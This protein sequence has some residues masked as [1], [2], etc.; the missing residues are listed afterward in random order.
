MAP[1]DRTL[2]I[3]NRGEI[4]L[5]VDP[6]LPPSSAIRSVAIFTE[7]DRR[8]PPCARGRRGL[9]VPRLPRHRRGGR[10]ARRQFGRTAPSTPATASCPSGPGSPAALE[11]AGLTLVGPSADGDGPDGSQG[12]GPR[13]RDRGGGPGRAVTGEPSDDAAFPGAGQGGR[14]RRRQGHADRAPG[15]GVRR[16][17]VAAAKR[18]AK[19]A[20]GD[21]TILVE[22]YVEHGR[23]IE[24]QV[25]ADAHGH[26][27]A[28]LRARLLHP[29]P[30]PEGARGGAGARPSRR[31]PQ[32]RHR[33]GG[34]P[35]RD[36]SATQNAGTV[37]FLLDTTG[38]GEPASTSSR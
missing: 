9:A 14:R 18:E 7:L 3:A 8:G 21:D 28:P 22:K 5:R 4:A 11:H 17:G 2:L 33:V 23:H 32:G 26:R 36:T 13:D 38:A 29:A 37:E 16:R 31:G 15:R 1:D 20:F 24:V 12:R 30:A 34:R 19:A 6:H 35:G 27:G 25:L 10:S